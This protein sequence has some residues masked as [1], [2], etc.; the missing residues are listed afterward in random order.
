MEAPRVNTLVIGAGRSGTTSLYDLMEQH[1][2]V[3]FSYL[4]EVHYFSIEELYNRGEHY[5]HGFLRDFA[6][7]RIVASA[8]TYLL[9]AYEAIKRIHRYN[10]GMKILVMLRDPVLRAWSSYHYS[11]NY[12]H[13]EAYGSF[14]DSIDNEKDLGSEGRIEKRNNLGHFHGSLYCLHLRK[15]MEFFPREQILLLETRKMKEDPVAFRKEL[16]GFL[17]VADREFEISRKNAAAVPRN[18]NLEKFLLDRDRGGRK[19]LRMLLPRF[20]K[21][22]LMR[23]GAVDRLHDLNR[24]Q[25][26][27]PH[28]PEEV[29]NEAIKFFKEDLTDL[30][31][32]FGINPAS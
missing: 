24:R 29:Y 23:S 30:Q 27:T 6:G 17:G 14:L 1:P 16:F 3:C 4:K 15:W 12:G 8:D 18:R 21:D 7:E 2:E 22:W 25:Q 11:V 5:Y 10:P 26:D 31:R 13:H 32:E 28:L 9:P 20:L 19:L